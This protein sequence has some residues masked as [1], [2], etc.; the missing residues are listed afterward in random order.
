MDLENYVPLSGK[1][2]VKLYLKAGWVIIP[3][4]GKGSHVK[5]KKDGVMAT[6]PMHKTLATGTEHA[7]LKELKK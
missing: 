2:M 4:Q 3:K 5:M 1:E 6:I 7:L